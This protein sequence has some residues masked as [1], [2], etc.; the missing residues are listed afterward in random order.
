[1]KKETLELLKQFLKAE[2]ADSSTTSKK[3]IAL[4]K[5]Y[6]NKI[7]SLVR[8]ILI[9]NKPIDVLRLTYDKQLLRLYQELHQK[10]FLLT[11]NYIEKVT[12]IYPLI[13]SDDVV[14]I[15][16]YAKIDLARIWNLIE[17]RDTKVME[18]YSF[19]QILANITT[20]I[21]TSIFG[22]IQDVTVKQIQ[23][24]DSNLIFD[25][26]SPDRTRPS[27]AMWLTEDDSKVCPI[28]FPLHGRIFEPNEEIP[29]IDCNP[30]DTHYGCRCRVVPI[31]ENGNPLLG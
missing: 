18:S 23:N 3:G 7:G 4:S 15:T 1:M 31:D 26:D 30:P 5:K 20:I 9:E 28:C 24:Q 2:G 13:T 11:L 8:Q 6:T 27:R 22:A 29:C 19:A 10:S 14:K 21:T 12:G 16:E 25:D 17:R